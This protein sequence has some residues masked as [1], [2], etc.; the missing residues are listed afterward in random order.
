MARFSVWE[1]VIAGWLRA[2]RL[3]SIR[4][5]ILAFAVLSALIPS[6]ATSWLS[7][8]ENKRALTERLTEQ[9]RGVS[10]QAAR[11]LDIWLKERVSDL[12][13]FARSVEVTDNL[14]RGGRAQTLARLT[15]YL[16]SVKHRFADYEE[17]LVID[18]AGR[19]VATSAG[20]RRGG[21]GGGAG[22][23]G[24][25]E[26]MTG[27]PSD[28]LTQVRADHP[29]VGAVHR[30]SALGRPVVPVAVPIR[31]PS[32][33]LLGALSAQVNLR[34]VED[35]L[36][37]LSRRAAGHVHVL[38][39]EGALITGFGAG[40][41]EPLSAGR[42]A[43]SPELLNLVGEA[44]EYTN[45]EGIRTVGTLARAPRLGWAVL[46]EMPTAEAYR[47]VLRLRNLTILI[48]AALLVVLG[49]VAYVLGLLIVRP[50]VR[51]TQGAAKVAAG[52]L[53]VDLPVVTGGEIGALTTVFNDMVARL[54]EGR[55]GLERLSVTDGLTGLFNRRQLME[56]LESEVRRARRNRHALALVIADID[57][58]KQYNDRFGHLAGDEVLRRVGAILRETTRDVDCV[59][60]FGGEEFVVLMPETDADAAVQAGE[61]LRAS[62]ADEVFRGGKVTLSIGVAQ[63]PDHADLPEALLACADEALY[64]A[65][66]GGRDRVVQAVR[67]RP[68]ESR[69]ET[70]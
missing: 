58:F 44:V 62:L 45:F 26:G 20:R 12:R 69:K 59:A 39:G 37:G 66:H 53:A 13:V 29:V 32:G 31:A 70:G 17:L 15:D 30:D 2:M 41:V 4:N 60:R 34:T 43:E 3:D 36:S 35:A 21:G 40:S 1:E 65:K 54:R 64:E 67:R 48:L 51:L 28:W 19:V 14:E 6:L 47:Q 50:V 63:F 52:D 57:Y 25:G 5:K 55:Q 33:R 61:R 9:L 56:T 22:G 38:T 49:L 16:N 46:A 7:Y 11:E 23:G 27:F 10:S 18:P 8:R 24:G 42:T 68:K